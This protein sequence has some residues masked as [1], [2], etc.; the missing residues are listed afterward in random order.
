MI[1]NCETIEDWRTLLARSQ[2]K[3]VFLF[4]HS[5]RCPISASRWKEFQSFAQGRDDAEFWV[6]LVIQD[7]PVSLQIAHDSGIAHQSPQAI[8]FDN[9]Q[10]VWHN[11]HWSITSQEMAHALDR[12]TAS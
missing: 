11:S 12:I 5:T 10:A 7:R 3:P 9:G 8:L 1:E 6:V 2:D 4:K